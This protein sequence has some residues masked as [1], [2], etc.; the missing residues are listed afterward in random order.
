MKA[1]ASQKGTA[2]KTGS[3]ALAGDACGVCRECP[4]QTGSLRSQQKP[5]AGS[6]A[7]AADACGVGLASL[8]ADDS[9][10]PGLGVFSTDGLACA[11][12][13]TPAASKLLQNWAFGPLEMCLRPH[14]K[15]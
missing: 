4:V 7:L 14:C 6:L 3:L 8:A 1:A 11:R 2:G 15:N 9:A 13:Q 5:A 12:Q 10:S